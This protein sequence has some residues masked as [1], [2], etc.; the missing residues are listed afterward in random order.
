MRGR[1]ARERGGGRKGQ[2][3]ERRDSRLA[4]VWGPRMVNRALLFF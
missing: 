1:E 3:W 2:R 4:L